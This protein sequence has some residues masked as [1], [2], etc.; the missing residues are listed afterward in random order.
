MRHF[1][2]HLTVLGSLCGLHAQNNLK[3]YVFLAEECPISIAMAAPLLEVSNAFST[4]LDLM[5]VF[6]NIKSDAISIRAF[7]DRHQLEDWQP[8]LDSEQQLARQLDAS[9]TPEAIIL[10]DERVVYRGR[11]SDAYSAPGRVRHGRINNELLIIVDQLLQE[12]AVATPWPE[13]V[14]CFITFLSASP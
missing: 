11:I 14:G 2:L 9:V 7:L 6:P 13:A 10:K 4:Q 8:V 12:G 1:F 3:I 5:A